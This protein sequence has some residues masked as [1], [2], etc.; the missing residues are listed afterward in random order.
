MV[1]ED[2][3]DFEEEEDEDYRLK[4]RGNISTVFSVIS[5]VL[6]GEFKIHNNQV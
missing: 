1:K 5:S 3:E 2:E 4:N 6:S